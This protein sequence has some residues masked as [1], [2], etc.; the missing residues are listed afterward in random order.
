MAKNNPLP[1]DAAPS[2][3]L[4]P[5]QI[6]AI[7]AIAADAIIALDDRLHITLFNDGASAIFGYSPSEIL[8]Q[9]LDLLI[10]ERMRAAHTHHVDEFAVSPVA[11]RKMGERREIFARR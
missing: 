3:A 8:G 5:S 9:Q 4:A 6:S 10:P 1:A 2:A 7:L 11:A